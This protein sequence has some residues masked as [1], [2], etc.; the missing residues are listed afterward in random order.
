MLVRLRS[1]SIALLGVVTAVGLSLIVFIAQIGFSGVLS[2]PIPSSQPE[3]GAVHD[4]I[5]LTRPAGV[6]RAHRAFSPA[7]AP[8]RGT[9]FRVK[10]NGRSP[11][12][13]DAGLGGSRQLAASPGQA[14][15]PAAPQPAPAPTSE[16][17]S[18]PAPSSNGSSQSTPTPTPASGDGGPSES[19]S[20]GAA[21][22]KGKHEGSGKPETSAATKGGSHQTSKTAG[23]SPSSSKSSGYPAGKY[24]GGTSEPP[25]KAAAPTSPPPPPPAKESSEGPG[26][27][28]KESGDGESSGKY[29]H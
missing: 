9:A 22:L 24:A 16:P 4:A 23:H 1:S 21:P 13:A 26:Y 17:T 8:R 25:P 18:Q 19:K 2:S 29:R 5:A 11:A 3:V 14:A 27:A 28:G 20:S 12:A 7:G 6:G 10:H 15:S